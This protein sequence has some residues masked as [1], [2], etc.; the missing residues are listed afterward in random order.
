M[1]PV[2]NVVKKEYIV[3]QIKI[4]ET[5]KFCVN[6]NNEPCQAG[7]K[8]WADVLMANC[9][10]KYPDKHLEFVKVKQYV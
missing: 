5:G 4:V 1:T 7:T 3:Y 8:A 10:S 6:E 2:F 9:K